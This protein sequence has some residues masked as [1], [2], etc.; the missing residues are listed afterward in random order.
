MSESL[1]TS[2]LL[3]LSTVVPAQESPSGCSTRARASTEPISVPISVP[4][5]VSNNHVY[6][7]ACYGTRMLW[8]LLDTG[9]GHSLLDMATAESLGATLGQRFEARGAGAGTSQ[10]AQLAGASVTIPGAAGSPIDIGAALALD[11]LSAFEGR[12]VE[13]ILGYNFIASYVLAIDYHGRRLLLHDKAAFRYQG[14]GARLPI[15]LPGNHPHLRA[16]LLLDDGGRFSGDFV[17]DVGSSL[18]LA[19][20]KPL[21]DH[22]RLLGR[23]GPTIQRPSGRGVGGSARPHIGRVGEVRLG[24]QVLRRPVTM[25]FGDSAGVFS[26]SSL[27]EGNIGGDLLRRFLVYFDYGR[28]EMVLEPNAAADEPFDTDMSGL[29]LSTDSAFARIKVAFVTPGTPAADAG[30]QVG[31]VIVAVDGRRVQKLEL[32]RVRRLFR[33]PESSHALTIRRDGAERV[34]QLRTRRLV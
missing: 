20:T 13:G 29:Q 27:F 26:T 32:E 15:T 19:L 14:S 30:L 22:N 21:V 9:A 11:D 3:A 33:L 8:F 24:T 1:T 6:L 4:I 5:E 31:D 28:Q 18:A 2:L 34:V 16:E 10:G 25:L 7:R 12:P 17:V 23:V